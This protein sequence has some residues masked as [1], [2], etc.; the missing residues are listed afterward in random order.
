MTRSIMIIGNGEI[1]AGLDHTIDVADLVMRFNDCR[2]IGA[3]GRKTD[4]V[5]VCNTGRPAKKMLEE[6]GWKDNPAVLAASSIWCVRDPR[7]FVDLR[8]PLAVSHPALDDFCDDY[9]DGYAEYCRE[10][11]KVLHVVPAATHEAVDRELAAFDPAPYVVPSTGLVA[12]AEFLARF[13]QAGD[14]ISVVGFGHRGW[15]WHPWQ[16][17]RQWVDARIADGTLNRLFKN[18]IKRSASGV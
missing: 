16:A 1:E 2:S 9:T 10:T 13:R 11:S 7:K 6:P 8:A 5:A 18:R 12:I 4:I 15:E 17:E 3:S 14:H